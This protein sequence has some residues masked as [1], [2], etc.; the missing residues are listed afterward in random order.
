MPRANR[1]KQNRPDQTGSEP[2]K[3]PGEVA[4]GNGGAG[5]KLFT[6]A[7][8]HGLRR[9]PLRDAFSLLPGACQVTAA[10]GRHSILLSTYPRPLSQRIGTPAKYK[11]SRRYANAG[12]PLSQYASINLLHLLSL[13]TQDTPVPVLNNCESQRWLSKLFPWLHTNLNPV[14]DYVLRTNG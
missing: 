4:V 10:L 2:T 5:W 14:V 9:G 8:G 1:T 6:W 13:P 12:G 3:S 11:P 7:G